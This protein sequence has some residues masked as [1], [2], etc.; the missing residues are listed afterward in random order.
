ME[1]IIGSGTVTP[2]PLGIV[3][4]SWHGSFTATEGGSD[5][6]LWW[7]HEKGKVVEGGKIKGLTIVTGFSNYKNYLG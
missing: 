5:Q 2:Y 6:F 3:D 1:K 7:A 4:A